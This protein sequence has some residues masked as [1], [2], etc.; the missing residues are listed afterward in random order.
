[1]LKFVIQVII[2]TVLSQQLFSQKPRLFVEYKVEKPNIT[3]VESL[4]ASSDSSLYTTK[5]I[6]QKNLDGKIN[7]E[8]SLFIKAEFTKINEI[9]IYSKISSDTIFFESIGRNKTYLAKDILNKYKWDIDY[10][11][12]KRINNYL[13]KKATTNFR[14]TQIV[15]WFTEDIP[16]PV[17]PWK[18]QDLPGLILEVYNVNEP[19]LYRWIASKIVYP[20]QNSSSLSFDNSNEIITYRSLV[21]LGDKRRKENQKRLRSKFKRSTVVNNSKT[22]RTSIEKIYEWETEDEKK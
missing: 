21:E 19:N 16:I 2:I 6:N 8:S 7:S 1:M 13:C 10:N 18:F 22:I 17:G 15:A 11:S 9:N 3:T 14:G 12:S 5:A 4:L 20:F